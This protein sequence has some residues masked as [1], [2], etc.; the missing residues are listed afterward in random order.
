MYQEVGSISKL[1]DHSQQQHGGV[2]R[3]VKFQGKGVTGYLECQVCGYLSPGFEK[4]LQKAH[5]HEE[6][7]LENEVNCS[8]YMNKI[9]TGSEAFNNSQQAFKVKI[10]KEIFLYLSLIS[11]S[12][13]SM[14]YLEWLLNVQRGNGKTATSQPK[15]YLKWTIISENIQ[16]KFVSL[17]ELYYIKYQLLRT[18]KCGHCGKTYLDNAEFHRHSA[19]THGDKIPDLVKDPEVRKMIFEF[20]QMVF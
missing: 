4:Y 15:Y 9:K 6:H 19:M 20:I 18:Y 2:F 3:V 14:K 16:S 8:K 10:R 7:P 17:I 13:M 12:L 1:Y 5:F 11:F